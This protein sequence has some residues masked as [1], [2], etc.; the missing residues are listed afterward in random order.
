ML[1]HEDRN[2]GYAAASLFLGSSI[3][4]WWTDLAFLLVLAPQPVCNSA[5]QGGLSVVAT[6]SFSEIMPLAKADAPCRQLSLLMPLLVTSSACLVR[7]SRATCPNFSQ[8]NSVPSGSYTTIANNLGRSYQALLI[9]G[10]SFALQVDA[11][12]RHGQIRHSS[13]VR[14]SIAYPNAPHS[15]VHDLCSEY[16]GTLEFCTAF[17]P[18]CRLCQLPAPLQAS[19]LM[20]AS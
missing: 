15:T 6:F 10:I 17:R 1:L 3:H 20:M 11:S 18:T 16:L 2:L 8:H 9:V 7:F 14:A 19:L 12:R 4:V 5:L 13:Q